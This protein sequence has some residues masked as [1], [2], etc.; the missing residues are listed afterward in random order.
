R[1][2]IVHVVASDREEGVDS[3]RLYRGIGAN[4]SALTYELLGEDKNAPFQ[5]DYEVPVGR[6]GQ[7]VSFRADATDV[8]GYAS[9]M[10]APRTLT[11]LADQPPK[12]KIVQPANNE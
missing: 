4:Q 2:I 11:I 1:S 8:D 7:V 6:V 3:V 9:T 10:S 12:A 5:F